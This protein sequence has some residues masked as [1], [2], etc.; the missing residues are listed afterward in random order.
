MINGTPRISRLLLGLLGAALV[1]LVGCS[2]ATPSPSAQISSSSSPSPVAVV[3]AAGFA[4][5]TCTANEELNLAFG[6]PDANVKSAAWKAFDAAVAAKDPTQI[7]AAAAAVLLHLEA[8]RAANARGA[9]WAPGTPANAEFTVVLAGL[10]KYI[11]TVQEARGEPGVEGQAAKDMGAV[12]PHL[13]AY[14]QM[15]QQL[16]VAKTITLTQLPC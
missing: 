4:T 14:Y 13:L 3:D 11:V 1:V 15:L 10:E 7:D 6:N 2:S 9:T 5:A 12:W 8:A 16:M